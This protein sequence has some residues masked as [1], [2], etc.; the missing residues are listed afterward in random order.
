MNAEFLALPP[1]VVAVV[2]RCVFWHIAGSYIP[3]E[4]RHAFKR[5]R[6]SLS[7]TNV[8]DVLGAFRVP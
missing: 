8:Q 5:R 3:A 6:R 7:T 2:R 4:A 1:S